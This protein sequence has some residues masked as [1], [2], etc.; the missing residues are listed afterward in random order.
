MLYKQVG[1]KRSECV[2]YVWLTENPGFLLFLVLHVNSS[3]LSHML[4]T[5]VR[6]TIVIMRLLFSLPVSANVVQSHP[7]M[8]NETTLYNLNKSLL[9]LLSF[10]NTCIQR[11]NHAFVHLSIY[12]SDVHLPLLPCSP[13]P[14]LP[15]DHT[16]PN[17]RLDVHFSKCTCQATSQSPTKYLF[18]GRLEC[19]F[20]QKRKK[21]CEYMMLL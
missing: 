6:C 4:T 16:E 15:F 10:L 5:W 17:L 3:L 2:G 18:F 9:Q 19:I 7:Q 20:P 14:G 21:L 13:L 1:E 11:S 12:S 8:R